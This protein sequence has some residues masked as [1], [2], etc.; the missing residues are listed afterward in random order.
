MSPKRESISIH[1]ELIPGVHR[2]DNKWGWTYAM[3]GS[4]GC[5]AGGDDQLE[6]FLA[7]YREVRKELRRII[8]TRLEKAARLTRGKDAI[9]RAKD[10]GLI[11]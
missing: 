2:D 8:E 9:Q 1:I 5:G 11:Q 3:D 6:T 4:G 10:K 7:A